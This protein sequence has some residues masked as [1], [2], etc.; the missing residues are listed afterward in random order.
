MNQPMGRF[1]SFM[2]TVGKNK[3]LIGMGVKGLLQEMPD[4]GADAQAKAAEMN[5]ETN[6][7]RLEEEQRQA[8]MEEERKQ[9]IAQLLMPYIQQNY[10]SLF[11]RQG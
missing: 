10:G 9:R 11:Q 8:K 4:A 5:A 1:A 7:M 6:R 3:D 2:D